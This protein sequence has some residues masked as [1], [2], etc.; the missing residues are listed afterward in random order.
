M[1]A[2]QSFLMGLSLGVGLASVFWGKAYAFI[3]RHAEWKEPVESK[4]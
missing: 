3:C 1:N 4:P 2:T